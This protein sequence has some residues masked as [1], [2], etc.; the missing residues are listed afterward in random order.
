MHSH[1]SVIKT[2]VVCDSFF[3]LVP[4]LPNLMAGGGEEGG[5]NAEC[6]VRVLA[7]ISLCPRHVRF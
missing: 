3:K 2:L 7:P 5:L 6:L 1:V 4:G